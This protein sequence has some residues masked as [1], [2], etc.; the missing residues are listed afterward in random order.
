MIRRSWASLLAVLLVTTWASAQAPAVKL[1]WHPGQVLH[2]RVETISQTTDALGDSRSE[3]KILLK[4]TKRWQVTA[5]DAAG[6]ATLQLSLTAM[7][8]ERT[9]P[10]GDV[11]IFD[12]A[13]PARTTPQLKEAL[14]KYLNTPLATLRVDGAGRVVEVK[15][16]MT[17]AS[18]YENELPFVGVL[19]VTGPAAGQAWE[20]PYKITLAPPLGTGEKYDALQRFACKAATAEHVTATFTTELKS[21][22]KAAADAIPLWQFLPT[23]EVVWDVKNGRLHSAKLTIDKELKGHQG[24]GSHTR[25][26]STTTVLYLG[27]R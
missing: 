21:A 23:G 15:G 10:S 12:S 4:V 19:P 18:G 7:T 1:R 26:Q 16:S 6:V 14:G 3:T 5:V 8:Q 24:E 11:L 13:N 27:S 17:H 20:R 2:Y 9:T 22:P 25:F